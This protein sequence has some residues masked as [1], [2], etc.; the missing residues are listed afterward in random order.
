MSKT[1]FEAYLEAQ[2]QDPAVKAEFDAYGAHIR[3]VQVLMAYFDARSDELGMNK[4]DIARQ[5]NLQPSNVRRWFT[6]QKQNPSFASMVELANCLDLEIKLV[7]KNPTQATKLA[8]DSARNSQ[9]QVS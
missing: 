7:P 6:G 5:L 4:T 8:E 9:L 1:N 2:L 3:S